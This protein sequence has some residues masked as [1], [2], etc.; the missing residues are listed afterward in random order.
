MRG[1]VRGCLTSQWRS[2]GDTRD[3]VTRGLEVMCLRPV[4]TVEME[5]EGCG[6]AHGGTA[7]RQDDREADRVFSAAVVAERMAWAIAYVEQARIACSDV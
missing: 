7:G 6:F 1:T 2:Y 3:A 5:G 4:Y